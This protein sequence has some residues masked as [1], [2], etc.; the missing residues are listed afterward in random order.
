MNCK[1]LTNKMEP[2]GPQMAQSNPKLHTFVKPGP[3]TC[4]KCRITLPD[5][6]VCVSQVVNEP[7]SGYKRA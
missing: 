2:V 7:F 3:H 1:K 5:G 6:K 4:W